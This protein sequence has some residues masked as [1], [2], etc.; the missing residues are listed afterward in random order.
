MTDRKLWRPGMHRHKYVRTLVMIVTLMIAGSQIFAQE[1]PPE[2]PLSGN[3][4][5]SKKAFSPAD[6]GQCRQVWSCGPAEPI[7]VKEATGERLTFLG[8]H[9]TMGTCRATA[10]SACR[11]C[12]AP[13]PAQTCT[14]QITTGSQ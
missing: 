14:W 6:N 10:D 13:R 2:R 4:V 7:E 12:T 3:G 5:W 8:D 9:E 1:S 11:S